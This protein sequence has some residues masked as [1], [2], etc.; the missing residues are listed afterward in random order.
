MATYVLDQAQATNAIFSCHKWK[1]EQLPGP[2]PI[3]SGWLDMDVG[4]HL[5]G[6][7]FPDVA[8]PWSL[9]TIEPISIAGWSMVLKFYNAPGS[10]VNPS[11]LP[12]L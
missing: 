6:I 10:L 1:S 2:P 11:L 8:E 3:F 5:I 7:G 4:L 9:H 12:R